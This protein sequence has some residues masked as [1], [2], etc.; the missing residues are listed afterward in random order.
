MDDNGM[1]LALGIVALVMAA[2]VAKRLDRLI[3]DVDLLV[4]GDV[5]TV[6][7]FRKLERREDG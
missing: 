7:L 6:K 4:D 1:A 2:M 5:E 3:R